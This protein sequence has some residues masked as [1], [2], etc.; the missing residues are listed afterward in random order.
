LLAEKVS[1][2]D[3]RV[4]MGDHRAVEAGKLAPQV[5]KALQGMKEGQ[6]SEIIQVETISTIVRLNKHTPAGTKKFEDVR[7]EL[8]K[9]LEKTK[10]NQVRAS[11]DKKLREK[12]KVEVL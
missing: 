9:Q 3:Y 10:T 12:A 11:L 1:E 8:K 4:M 7:D 2:D 6:V 5:V